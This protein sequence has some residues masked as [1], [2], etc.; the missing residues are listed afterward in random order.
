LRAGSIVSQ[1]PEKVLKRTTGLEPATF[2]LG[3][4]R[5]PG[6]SAR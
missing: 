3:M 6:F 4:R 5:T 1:V 2:G